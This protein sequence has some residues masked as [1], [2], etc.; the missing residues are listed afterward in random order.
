MLIEGAA[1]LLAAGCAMAAVWGI[2]E[3]LG[4]LEQLHAGPRLARALAPLRLAGRS[5]RE[6]T[7]PERRR[8][9]ALFAAVALAAGWMVSGPVAGVVPAI[10][11]PWIV[12]RAVA[13][14]RRRWRSALAEGAAA[15]ARALA[16]AL[17]GGHGI[18]GGLQEIARVGGVPEPAAG[19][20]RE[21]GRRLALGETTD[22]VLE[23]LADRA[24]SSEW[25]TLVAAI[26]LQRDAGGDLAGLLRTFASSC[27]HSRRLEAEAHGMTGQVR[28]TARLV[29]GMPFA[30]LALSEV[31]A[32]GTLL[33]LIGDGRSRLLL[34]GGVVLGAIGLVV[35]SR[36]AR[37]LDR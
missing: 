4:E 14:R 9:A 18:R 11:G 32:P 27:E 3:A 7:G 16:D 5:G 35:V 17:A 26:L 19:E 36:M 2:W 31:I 25:D 13:W 1:P 6:P 22:I 23:R 12:K 24:D 8:L 15:V 34:I 21:A 28:V 33:A 20:L 30:G 37:V 10:A 29:A